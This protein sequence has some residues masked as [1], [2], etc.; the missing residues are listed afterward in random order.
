LGLSAVLCLVG[1]LGTAAR[2]VLW[3]HTTSAEAALSL[4]ALLAGGGALAVV[5]QERAPAPG[6]EVAQATRAERATALATVLALVALGAAGVESWWR[7]G[8]YL[9][10]G[11]L[12]AASAALL[13]LAALEPTRLVGTRRLAL[14]VALVV[15]AV[16]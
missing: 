7:A 15:V 5:L 9:T 13:G 3:E 10:S 2:V 11:T 1:A 6:L 4:A 8:S 16:G 14:L 12:V